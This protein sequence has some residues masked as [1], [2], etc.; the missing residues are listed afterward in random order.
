M[1]SQ[2]LKKAIYYKF[3]LIIQWHM[4]ILSNR[5]IGDTIKCLK[6]KLKLVHQNKPQWQ[7]WI[8]ALK[9]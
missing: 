7:Q 6:Y 1:S 4:S 8:I 5:F 3:E 9:H 2:V